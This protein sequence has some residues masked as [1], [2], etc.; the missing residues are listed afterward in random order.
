M[1][2]ILLFLSLC[3]CGISQATT[4]YISPGGND[5]SGTGTVGNPWKTLYKATST[6]TTAGDIIHVNAGTYVETIQCNLNVGVSIEGD[7]VT[8]IIKSTLT[9]PYF[10]LL[11]CASVVGTNGNQHVSNLKFDGQMAT[12]WGFDIEGRSNFSIHDCTIVD[13]FDRGVIWAGGE[14]FADG[15][16]SVY[17]TGNSFYNNIMHNCAD[18]NVYG[19]GC[20]NFGGQDGMLIYN[21]TIT[22]TQ[23]PQGQNGWPI[24]AAAGGF[25]KG[26]K[27]YNNILTKIPMG[28]DAGFYGWDFCI[29]LFNEV[30]GNEIYNNTIQGSIDMNYQSKGAYAYS[31]YIHDNTI[32]QPVLNTWRENGIIFEFSTPDAIVSNNH[33]KNITYGIVF[34]TRA[35]DQVTNVTIKNN[36]FENIGQNLG[37][38]GNAGAAIATYSEGTDDY[39]VNNMH[40][41]NNTAI[42]A[43]GNAP[44]NGIRFNGAAAVLNT[45]INNNVFQGFYEAWL[46]GYPSNII[47][48]ISLENN[49]LYL[50]GNNN[51]PTWYIGVPTN[52]TTANNVNTNPNLD[53]GFHPTGTPLVDAGINVGIAYNGSAPDMGFFETGGA[54]AT[55]I[56]AFTPTTA[57][58]GVTVTITGTN[59][60][61]AT[62]VSFGG[63]A[64]ASF[65]IVNST[66]ITAVVAGGSTGSVSVTTASNT[67]SLAGFTYSSANIAPTANAGLD[68][69]ITL[70]TNSVSLSG[71]GNDPDG[72]ITAYS[73]TKI[74]GPAAGTI[75]NAANAAT[76][77]TALVQGVYKFELKVTD[78]SGAV[79]RDTMQVTVNA[80]A[81]IA[82]TANAGLDQNIT[83]PTNSVSLSGSGNDPDGSIT[84]YSWTKISGPAGPVI[85]NASAAATS[86]TGFVQGIYKFELKVT[87]NSGAVGRDTMQVIIFAPNTA[88]TANA[89]LDQSIT[90]PT[91]N[92]TLSGSGNDPD[93]TIT[94][95]S[96][97][98]I[99]GPGTGT[100]TSPSLPGTTIAGLTAGIYLFELKVTDNNGA[101][102][103]DT[104]QVTVNQENSA[105]TADAGIDQTITLPIDNVTL[106]GRGI[107]LDGTI[108][109]YKWKQVSGPVDKLTSTNT[110]V[111]V[112]NSLIEGSY[113]FELTVTDNKGAT[114]KD[115]V[116]VIVK[117]QITT[118]Q[119]NTLT[120][121]PNP[122]VDIT[123]LEINAT[124]NNSTLLLVIT[125][126]QGKNVYKKQLVVA[127]NNIKE[128]I[129]FRTI[130][131]GTYLVT[132]YFMNQERQTVKA[133]KF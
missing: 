102:G 107:D 126:M 118:P 9:T 91:N 74:S 52:I 70:P 60:T 76:T 34:N 130:A 123:T 50:N 44:G 16:P 8:S 14:G 75:T 12:T 68:Q 25:I 109:A 80:A 1:K 88:P 38:N 64:A 20:L 39:I 72:S 105:P 27:I 67:G 104:V 97:T 19:R 15:A 53:A 57:A 131:K 121:Y 31:M 51:N 96:W 56:T 128:R 86:V 93:G 94:A 77:V 132:V 83:L 2:K 124:S 29:E 111:T 7:G 129:D 47:N 90:L 85:T 81:N 114:D 55:T 32:M 82:P 10:A 99:S 98:K 22:Q 6:V 21:N 23:R 3:I 108:T 84:A 13:F 73:W 26:C 28:G 37:T 125:D 5:A 4:Y 18:Y 78:N 61:G 87:D 133:I 41:Y 46:I 79:G 42:A 30:G 35:L 62:A 43:P 69:N 58:T 66:T 49:S 63:T 24:K 45:K 103:K 117:P 33:F 17:A 106:S 59:F 11:R 40:I 36:L 110:A 100:I 122:I 71:S 127:N 48:T 92:A 115:T 89:G 119:N 113:K 54:A 95:Y 120:I 112:L 116:N 101:T 65:I